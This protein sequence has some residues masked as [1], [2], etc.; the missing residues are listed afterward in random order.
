MKITH[1]AIYTS[2]VVDNEVVFTTYLTSLMLSLC[3]LHKAMIPVSQDRFIVI[4]I[5]RSQ[6]MLTYRIVDQPTQSLVEANDKK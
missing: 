1:T 6:A 5:Q 3:S 2:N 4:N